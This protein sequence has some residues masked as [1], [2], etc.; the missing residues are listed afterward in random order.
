MA[1]SWREL[2]LRKP[3]AVDSAFTLAFWRNLKP[4][5][6]ANTTLV[7]LCYRE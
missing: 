5:G 2:N 1:A 4:H 3:A 6:T 7:P